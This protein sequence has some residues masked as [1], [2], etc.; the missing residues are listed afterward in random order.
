[1]RSPPERREPGHKDPAPPQ[2]AD[3]RLN[4]DRSPDLSPADVLRRC[5]TDDD[6][7]LHLCPGEAEPRVAAF[8]QMVADGCFDQADVMAANVERIVAVHLADNELRRR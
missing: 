6:G 3:Q 1:M 7:A 4:G 5:H 2:D 8:A